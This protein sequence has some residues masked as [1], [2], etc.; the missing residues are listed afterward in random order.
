MRQN[1]QAIQSMHLTHNVLHKLYDGAGK[2]CICSMTGDIQSPTILSIIS[3]IPKIESLSN[4]QGTGFMNR[5]SES[6]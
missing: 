6:K 5:G 3:V 1:A 2:V 4:K